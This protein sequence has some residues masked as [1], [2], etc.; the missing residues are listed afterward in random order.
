MFPELNRIQPQG[1]PQAYQT[2]AIR[3]PRAPEAWVPASCEDVDCPAWTNGWVTRVPWGSD[4]AEAVM[5]SGRPFTETTVPGRP[6]REFM[7]PPGTPCFQAS[8]HRKMARPDIPDLFVVR[9]G[10]W[11]GNPTGV[12]RVHQRPDDW[13]EHLQETTAR[14]A[15]EI[16][17]G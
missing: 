14:V 9:D 2:F 8:R 3:R 5:A 16:E 7:F 11:R 13:V 12:R 6:E 4:M 17:K 15:D 10:D 1:P